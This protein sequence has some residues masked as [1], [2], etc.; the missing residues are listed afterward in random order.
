[1]NDIKLSFVIPAKNENK[2]IKS[3]IDSIKGDE[4]SR[5]ASEII[6]VDNGSTDNTVD[7]AIDAGAK[8]FVRRDLKISGLRN[9]GA[10][11]SK[12]EILC[13]VDADVVILS[14][15]K[16]NAIRVLNNTING[17]VGCSPDIPP[18]SSWVTQ[19]WCLQADVREDEGKRAWLPSMNMAMRREVFFEF[20]GFNENLVTGEDVDLGIRVARK[21]NIINS[22]KLMAIHY[23]EAKTL[24]HL[25]KKEYWRGT[26]NLVGI[27]S[28]G[29]SIRELPSIIFPLLNVII[30]FSNPIFYSYS[31]NLYS[32]NLIILV[33]PLLKTLQIIC[34]TREIKKIIP[35]YIVWFV[36]SM[37]RTAS[38]FREI[39][40]IIKNFPKNTFG[41]FWGSG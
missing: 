35:L 20:K 27:L 1:M 31:K 19:A 10:S 8:V 7:L 5:F 34:M 25:F 40:L 9:F 36:Y 15:W 22:K 2:N 14:G 33:F 13:F 6:V 12:G 23:G 17:M 26:S 38:C 32:A 28:H 11:K 21:Y 18:G 39:I 29:I 41:S 37:A 24:V 30:L 4:S 16:A 3:C